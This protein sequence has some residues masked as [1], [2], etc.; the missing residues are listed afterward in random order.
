[1]Y[2]TK[3]RLC[4]SQADL[5]CP[6]ETDGAGSLYDTSHILILKNLQ[7]LPQEEYPSLL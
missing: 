5:K 7:A 3:N 2:H 1:M 6:N 4:L